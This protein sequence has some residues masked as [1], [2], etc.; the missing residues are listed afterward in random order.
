MNTKIKPKSKQHAAPAGSYSMID[1]GLTGN[2]LLEWLK[3]QSPAVMKA[4]IG[5][6]GHYN[7]FDPLSSLPEVK[8]VKRDFEGRYGT[9][10]ALVLPTPTVYPE[11]D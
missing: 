5:F 11:P 2:D 4:P 9:F 6:T 7:E 8:D 10:R 1:K 3:Q